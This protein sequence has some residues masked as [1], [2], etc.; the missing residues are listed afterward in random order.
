M[1]CFN[2]GQAGHRASDC[3][4]VSVRARDDGRLFASQRLPLRRSSPVRAFFAVALATK[5]PAVPRSYVSTADCPVSLCAPRLRLR[6]AACDSGARRHGDPDVP[7][8]QARSCRR[9]RALRIPGDRFGSTIR[10]RAARSGRA[11]ELGARPTSAP[12]RG[13]A[14]AS[15]AQP[16]PLEA[17]ANCGLQHVRCM[18]CGERGHVACDFPYPPNTDGSSRRPDRSAEHRDAHAR[19][20]SQR[21]PRVPTAEERAIRRS[22]ATPRTRRTLSGLA[23]RPPRTCR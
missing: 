5:F 17:A 18:T 22:A 3:T 14:A 15:P 2:C 20:A 13:R 8:H 10:V 23:S 11:R 19:A 21:S 9:Q 12:H 4:N 7:G 16:T 1:K 6:R